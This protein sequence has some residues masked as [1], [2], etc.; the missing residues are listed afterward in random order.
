MAIDITRFRFKASIQV[1]HYEIDWQGIVHNAVYL[2]YFETGRVSYLQHLGVPVDP[3]AI[4]KQSR[5]VVARNEIDYVS[6]ARFGD[7][8]DLF[9]R[10]SFVRNS[11]FGFEGVLE[12]QRSKRRIAEAVS[13][14][15]WLDERTG[16]PSSVDDWFRSAV[17]EYEGENVRVVR[18]PRMV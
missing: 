1:R 14:L 16:K 5:I 6:P 2:T 8:L 10:I 17:S 4:R 12:E 11:S 15:V 3:D 9:T 18:P 7:V 13:I